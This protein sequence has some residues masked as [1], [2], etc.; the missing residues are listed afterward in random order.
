MRR[1][2][3]LSKSKGWRK[4]TE[5]GERVMRRKE[6]IGEGISFV[7]KGRIIFGGAIGW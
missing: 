5:G 6:L 3:R 1:D 2:R 7:R 4:S